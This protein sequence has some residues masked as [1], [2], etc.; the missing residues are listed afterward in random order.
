MIK[1]LQSE[2]KKTNWSIRSILQTVLVTNQ[3][4]VLQRRNASSSS[5]SLLP[6]LLRLRSVDETIDDNLD[7]TLLGVDSFRFTKI[8]VGEA[9]LS[10]RA[11]RFDDRGAVVAVAVAAFVPTVVSI[12]IGA[13]LCFFLV[14]NKPDG[15]TEVVIEKQ[16]RFFREE[17]QLGSLR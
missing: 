1:I 2:V 9:E 6:L 10:F 14:P 16:L 15:L 3:F 13:A 8:F 17:I 11:V 7:A 12:D 5:S 4:S